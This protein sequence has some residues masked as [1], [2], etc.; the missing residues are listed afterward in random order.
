MMRIKFHSCLFLSFLY[1]AGLGQ[2]PST[3]SEE[4][5]EIITY[6]FNDPNPVPISTSSK[7]IKI[8]PYTVFEGYSKEGKKQKWKV[9]KLENDYVEVYVLPEIGGKIWGAIE[10]S[11]GKEFIYRNE[12]IKFRNIAMRGPWTSGGIE[13]NFGIIGHHPSTANPVDY[14]TKKNEDGSVSCIVGNL[15]LPSRTNWRVEVRL[16]KD[17]A[18]VETKASWNNPT[19]IHQSY[20]NWMTAAAVVT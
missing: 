13:F 1:T 10:K 4:E 19:P 3:I 20:Y 2:S 5:R 8:Y 15:D 7:H 18:Y 6:P 12:V 9:V 11:T 17:K 16:P 14:I